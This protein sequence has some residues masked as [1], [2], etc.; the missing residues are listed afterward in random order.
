MK[1][2]ISLLLALALMFTLVLTACGAQD[3]P[4]TDEPV[5]TETETQDNENAEMSSKLLM[6][7]TTSTD[8]TGLLDALKPIFEEETGIELEWVAVG[9]GEALRMGE[10]G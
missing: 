6:A 8:N 9:T 2:R 4:V 7:T 1:K 3:E 5:E 10:D